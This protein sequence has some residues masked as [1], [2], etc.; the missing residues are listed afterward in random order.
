MV[1][2]KLLE[3][4][5]PPEVYIV[6]DKL[7]HHN[8]KGLGE[9]AR[10]E[11][12]SSEDE[13]AL[14]FKERL[15]NAGVASEIHIVSQGDVRHLPRNQNS[16]LICDS[17][18]GGTVFEWNSDNHQPEVCGWRGPVLLVTLSGFLMCA[19][20]AG[21]VIDDGALKTKKGTKELVR[22]KFWIHLKRFL[23]TWDS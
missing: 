19:Q 23:E 18:T 14:W 9:K 11:E 8:P 1:A 22:E 16:W 5:P 4:V 13:Y 15:V 12:E 2:S 17:H 20:H 3:T 10:R 21:I 6:A 7:D